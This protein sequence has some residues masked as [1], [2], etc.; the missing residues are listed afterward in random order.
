MVE[1]AALLAVALVA[2]GLALTGPPDASRPAPAAESG[3]VVYMG[4]LVLDIQKHLAVAGWDPGPVDGILGPRTG[5][6]IAAF[7]AAVG[8]PADGLPSPCVLAAA[9]RQRPVCR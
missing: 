1:A 5:R 2:V 7:Q 3:P 6:A 8:L 9:R 4:P